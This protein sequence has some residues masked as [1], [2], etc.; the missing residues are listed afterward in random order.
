MD[1]SQLWKDEYLDAYIIPWAINITMAVV[2][3]FIGRIIAKI[4][5]GWLKKIMQRTKVDDM[6]NDF[7]CNISYAALLGFVIIAALNQLGVDTTSIMAIF[8]AAGLAIGLA[9]KDSLANFSAGVMLVF[10][11]PFKIDDFIEAGGASGIVEKITIFN[12]VVRTP[13]NRETTIPNGHIYGNTIVNYS[14]RDTRRVDMVFGIGYDDDIKLA[15]NLIANVIKNDSRILAEPEPTIMISELADSSVNI[16]VRPWVN[17]A[18]YWNVRSD[19]LENVKLSFDE[20][21]ISIPFPQRDLHIINTDQN[22]STS[23]D[24]VAA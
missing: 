1:L 7:I 8:A 6:L 17:S 10:F 19:M 15:K 11:K 18:D 9:L 2:I 14:A 5:K 4:I 24:K 20:N 16:A 22:I 21:G 12:T 13:D 3:F 23:P